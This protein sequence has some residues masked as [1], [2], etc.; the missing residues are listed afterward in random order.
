MNDPIVPPLVQDDDRLRALNDLRLLDTPPEQ[1]FDDIAQLATL[2]C[3]TPVGLVSLVS[4]DRQWFKARV[5]FP[6][7]QTDL[8]ASVCAYS[9][10]ESDLRSFRT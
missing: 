6:A 2:V 8:N 4:G 9:L 3:A 10:S 7:C 5:G 1:S